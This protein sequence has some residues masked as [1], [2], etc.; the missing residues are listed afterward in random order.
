MVSKWV[1]EGR[2]FVIKSVVYVSNRDIMNGRERG[3]GGRG[4]EVR[5]LRSRILTDRDSV[6]Q[7]SNLQ[8]SKC[9]LKKNTE[10]NT[11]LLLLLL[12]GGTNHVRRSGEGMKD[13]KAKNLSIQQGES[14]VSHAEQR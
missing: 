9:K 5:T 13:K 14:V 2:N 12:T 3:E 4:G 10:T 1:T 8:T 7:T 6:R 11:L